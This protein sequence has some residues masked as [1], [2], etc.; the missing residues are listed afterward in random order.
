MKKYVLLTSLLA[1][2]ACG[3][4]SGSGSGHIARPSSGVATAANMWEFD[5]SS[6]VNEGNKNITNMSSYT[7]DYGT[8]ETA[9]KQAMV[10]YVNDHLGSGTRGGLLNRAA[11]RQSTMSRTRDDNF[12][13]EEFARADQ[14]LQ[15]MKQSIYD[16][17]NKTGEELTEYVTNNKSNVVTALILL[18]KNVS[19]ET[20]PDD[21][22]TAFGTLDY[23]G[24]PLTAAN[25]MSYLDSFDSTK[26]EITKSRMENVR[27]NDT[28]GEGFFKFTLDDSGKIESV[29]LM[30]DPT[31]EYGSSWADTRIIIATS[32]ENVGQ[33]IQD[34]GHGLNPFNTDYLTDKAGVLRRQSNGT[35]FSN[36]VHYYKFTLGKYTDDGSFSLPSGYNSSTVLEPK[37][38]EKIE[39]TSEEELT[40]EMARQKLIEYVI[41][42]VNKKIHNQHGDD[43]ATD[44][45]DAI[46]VVNW[47]IDKINN[48]ITSEAAIT[49]EQG[50]YQGDINQ[51]AAMYGIGKDVKLK[52]SDFGYAKLVRDDGEHASGTSYLTY[53]GG[54]DERRM[55]NT[56]A[57]N[58]LE[59]G[60][61]FNGTAVITVEDHDKNKNTNDEVTRTALYKDT[62]AKLQYN[63]VNNAA[64]HTL[65][66]NKLKAVEGASA[67]SDWYS[68]VVQ[69]TEGDPAM[70]VTLNAAG[71]KIDATYQFFKYND[72]GNI[73]RNKNLSTNDQIV[74]TGGTAPNTINM[75]DGTQP[76]TDD[77]YRLQGSAT[78]EYYGQ[79][80]TRPTEATA[81]F[82]MDERYHNDN[83]TI[84]HE[85]SVYGAFG[86]TKNE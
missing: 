59:N 22:I 16:M 28:G 36:T 41:A 21:L 25:V 11:T 56:P 34:T 15:V 50:A 53:V 20:E 73:V 44:L 42:K 19:E 48:T 81:G 83:N 79:D 46:A 26:F 68:M 65:T 12:T 69:G 37:E 80:A 38:F 55:D 18:D 78:A 47:Y 57:N 43:N 31:S 29:A 82:W 8:S 6:A 9:T 1:L 14:A 3:G 60:A 39:L 17:A 62:T 33:A 27:L 5:A 72:Q 77:H 32:G 45:A 13:A 54:Y 30:E 76:T 75:I 7:V 52:Y 10:T 58:N 66:M 84:Q 51:V 35:A 61:T 40:P 49:G 2:A 4:G 23:L 71:K 64:Q 24:D 67:G 63:V 74:K 70:N 85:L 86:G